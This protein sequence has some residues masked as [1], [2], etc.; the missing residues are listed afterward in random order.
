MLKGSILM[1][2]L[3][4]GFVRLNIS[5][6][7]KAHLTHYYQPIIFSF[8]KTVVTTWKSYENSRKTSGISLKN[9]QALLKENMKELENVV[10]QDS[11]AKN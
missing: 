8:F 11:E 7:E 1:R 3:I 6:M 10:F 9:E 4:V 5:M 2:L